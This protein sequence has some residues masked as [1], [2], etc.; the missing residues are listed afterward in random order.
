MHFVIVSSIVIVKV[1]EPSVFFV[2]DVVHS[3]KDIILMYT[4]LNAPENTN[5]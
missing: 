5:S 4:K 1:E 3:K 2:K